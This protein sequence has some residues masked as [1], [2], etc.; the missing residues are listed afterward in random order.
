MFKDLPY[1]NN[2]TQLCVRASG[3]DPNSLEGIL[4]ELYKPITELK[5]IQKWNLICIK[6]TEASPIS[7]ILRFEIK[8]ISRV[9]LRRYDCFCYELYTLLNVKLCF[10]VILPTK[11]IS[12]TLRPS[13]EG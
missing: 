2:S 3:P 1:G 5:K 10:V 13:S 9:V 7:L 12:V 4:I 6:I 11:Y 8:W